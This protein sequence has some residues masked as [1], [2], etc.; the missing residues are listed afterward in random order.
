VLEHP[1]PYFLSL[2]T[3][4][5]WLPVPLATVSE[6]GNAYARGVPWTRPGRFVGNGAFQLKSWQ[7]NHEVVVEKSP[8]YWDAASF[9]CRAF[10]SIPSKTS[11]PRNARFVQANYT[12]R[13]FCLSEKWTPIAQ[14]SPAASNGSLSEYLLL[15]AERPSVR[16]EQ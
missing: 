11:M 9:A 5:T 7:P 16:A 4:A 13:M 3:H 2:L 12:S 14:L 15:P 1:T 6:H 10:I 8:T